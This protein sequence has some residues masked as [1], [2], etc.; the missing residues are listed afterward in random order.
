MSLLRILLIWVLLF[1]PA[2]LALAQGSQVAFGSVQENKD[3]P[4]EVTSDSLEI[5][6]NAGRAIFTDNVVIVQGEMRLTADKVVVIYDTETQD[7][8]DVEAIGNVVLISGEDAAEAERAD[9]SVENGTIIMTGNVLV[10]Q[11]PTA[12]TSDR[13]TVWLEDGTAQMSGRVRTVLQSGDD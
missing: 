11:G 8:T 12:V 5:D 6:Q 3:E 4:V 9:Y 2:S 1:A 10:A 13:M 7:M